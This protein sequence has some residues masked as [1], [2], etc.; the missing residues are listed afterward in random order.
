MVSPLFQNGIVSNQEIVVM[1]KAQRAHLKTIHDSEGD[2]AIDCTCFV[3]FVTD[4]LLPTGVVGVVRS[5]DFLPATK[6]SM[7]DCEGLFIFETI[8][9]RIRAA[10]GV[11]LNSLVMYF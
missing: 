2:G 10:E 11:P 6:L 4:D 1:E 5:G 9:M 3:V 7:T 8:T